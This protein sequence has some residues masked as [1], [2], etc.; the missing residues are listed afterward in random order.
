[1]LVLKK[2]KR[3]ENTHATTVWSNEHARH[4]NVR[5][6]NICYEARRQFACK[7]RELRNTRAPPIEHP[8]PRGHGFS[9]RPRP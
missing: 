9:G 4:T 5:V 7:S 8:S 6:A 3:K 2:K 1:M